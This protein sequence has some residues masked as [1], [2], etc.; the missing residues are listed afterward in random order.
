MIWPTDYIALTIIIISVIL[1]TISAPHSNAFY[2][3]EMLIELY[4]SVYFL[5]FILIWGAL[6]ITFYITNRV[7][8]AK[9][10]TDCEALTDW[11]VQL[12]A[13]SYGCLAG[14]WGGFCVTLMKSAISII[15]GQ[16]EKDGIVG[17][18]SSWLMWVLLFALIVSWISQLIWINCG[19]SHCPAMFIVSL[20][21]IFNELIGI[22]G[23]ILYFQ[24]FRLFSPG[25]A[26]MF[27]IGMA[28]GIAGVSVLA[29]RAQ[30]V[31]FTMKEEKDKDS[32][33][34]DVNNVRRSSIR[35][36]GDTQEAS[37]ETFFGK[38]KNFLH[39]RKSRVTSHGE[40]EMHN[41]GEYPGGSQTEEY[42]ETTLHSA[43]SNRSLSEKVRESFRRSNNS[44]SADTS[45]IV[46]EMDISRDGVFDILG[47]TGIP[48]IAEAVVLAPPGVSGISATPPPASAS[49]RR[50]SMVSQYGSAGYDGQRDSVVERSEF[51]SKEGN[52]DSDA[53]LSSESGTDS[54]V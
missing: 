27:A 7:L 39:R 41:Q 26:A 3:T 48:D 32:D 6:V 5:T 1:T 52:N 54:L 30:D 29:T 35:S 9:I 45:G 49:K 15:A 33:A 18:L 17:V 25:F 42:D 13:F 16:F 14:L 10:I 2:T 51:E 37:S 19:L 53:K 12:L 44:Q 11:Q 22:A 47:L 50:S 4:E 34:S 28:C 21:A 20:E 24:E 31:T 23:G 8:Y 38:I 43:I 40:M 46:S 36:V